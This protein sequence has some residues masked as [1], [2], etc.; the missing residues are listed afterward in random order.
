MTNPIAD[1]KLALTILGD[2]QA[3]LPIFA[4]GLL[5]LKTAWANKSNT[6][7]FANDVNQFMTDWTPLLTQLMSMIPQNQQ[8]TTTTT[9]AK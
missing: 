9:S 7:E 1:I 8:P 5:D 4:K 3:D 6:Q 2:V